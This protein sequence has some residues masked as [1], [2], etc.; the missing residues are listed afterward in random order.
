MEEGDEKRGWDISDLKFDNPRKE[1]GG[2]GREIELEWLRKPTCRIFQ[3]RKR[4]F[5]RE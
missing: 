4:T 1:E 2:K 3:E 5:E